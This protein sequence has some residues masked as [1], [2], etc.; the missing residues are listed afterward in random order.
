[1][2]CLNV[3]LNVKDA[4]NVDAVRDMLAECG[5]QSRDEPGCI[6]FEV[7]HD[8]DNPLTFILCERW[9]S[10]QAWIDHKERDAVQTIYLPKV[11]PLVERTPH[12][13]DLVE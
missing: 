10:E 7:C 13:C 2:F 12:F 3:F 1:M 6:S 11:I 9:E 5:R 4:A 8:R